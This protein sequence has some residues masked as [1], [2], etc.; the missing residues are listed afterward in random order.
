MNKNIDWGLTLI[1]VYVYLTGVK[2]LNDVIIFDI[3][4]FD[5]TLKVNCLNTGNGFNHISGL[6]FV[7]F[8]ISE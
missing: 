4:P 1:K 8:P 2:I 7:Q 3:L 6:Q 5:M